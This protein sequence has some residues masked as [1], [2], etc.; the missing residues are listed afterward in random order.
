M[1]NNFHRKEKPIQ[2]MM[3]MGGGATGS[4]VRG[5]AAAVDVEL[6]IYG[7]KSSNG[8]R[9]GGS[10]YGGYTRITG[11]ATPG[12]TFAYICGVANGNQNFYSGGPGSGVNGSGGGFA[13]VWVNDS[14]VSPVSRNASYVLGVAGGSGAGGNDGYGDSRG[15]AGGGPNGSDCPESPNQNLKGRGATP[16]GGGANGPGGS[17]GGA[18]YGGN[19]GPGSEHCGGGGGGWFGGGGGG[20]NNSYDCGGGGG[21]GYTGPSS[22]TVTNPHGEFVVTGVES[23]LGGYPGPG[24]PGPVGSAYPHTGD[25]HPATTGRVYIIVDGVEVHDGRSNPS[26]A[27]STHQI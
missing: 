25:S 22:R 10:P 2:G 11:T 13:G 12:T 16:S 7:G 26:S 21:C 4:L 8:G 19:G 18:W 1:F 27:A 15:G 6:H 23:I 24:A 3:G 17:S 9:G 20:S 14:N 5:G